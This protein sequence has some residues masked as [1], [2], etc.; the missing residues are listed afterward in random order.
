MS[1]SSQDIQKSRYYRVSSDPSTQFWIMNVLGWIGISLVTYFTLSRPYNQFE[2]SYLAHNV[3]QSIAGLLLSLPMRYLFRVCWDWPTWQRIVVN[4]LTVLLISTLWA[5]GRLLLFMAMTDERDLW[6]DFGGWWF[7]SIFVFLAWA[8]LYHGIK[9]HRLLQSEHEQLLVLE[10][11]QR[12]DALKRAEAESAARES[13]LQLL[14]YQL[15]PHFLFN[16]LNAINALISAERANDAKP[17]LLKLSNF[18][19]YSLESDEQLTVELRQELDAASLYLEIE[20]VRFSDRLTLHTDIDDGIDDVQ[21]PSLI[22]Q[23]LLENAIKYAIAQSEEGGV[24]KVAANLNNNTLVLTVEDSG[25]DAV[26]LSKVTDSDSD[27]DAGTG[28][29]LANIKA[30]LRNLYGRQSS[31]AVDRSMLGGRR[32]V[33]SLPVHRGTLVLGEQR[34]AG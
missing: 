24:I 3:L 30:R 16:T 2:L 29:G 13:Q 7:P 4:V 17:M 23:P 10:S 11:R 1:M 21:V 14:R 31:V 25:S 9:Y 27:S 19:R 34:Y 32:V 6:G 12:H 28:I 8:A 26:P 33:L 22:L 5:G 20:Q 15:N 18:L